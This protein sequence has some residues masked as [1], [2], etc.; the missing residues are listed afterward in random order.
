MKRVPIE[1]SLDWTYETAISKIRAD[2]DAIE[3]LGATHVSIESQTEWGVHFVSI[4]AINER[5]ETDAEFKQRVDLMKQREE[6]AK[7][8]ELQQLK[9]LKEKYNQ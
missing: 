3:K 1:Y 9:L 2:L 4:Y 5:L 7:Q 6:E 8:R